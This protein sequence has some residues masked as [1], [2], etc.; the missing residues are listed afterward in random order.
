MIFKSLYPI[1][2]VPSDVVYKAAG[3]L[4][5][6]AH[7][8]AASVQVALLR[9]LI[10]IHCA[11]ED[12]NALSSLYTVFFN[13]LG[14]MDIRL[15]LCHLLATITRKKHVRPYR[16]EIL[17]QLAH[18]VP[19]EPALEKLTRIYDHLGSHSPDTVGGK[20]LAVTFA[21]PDPVWG[22]R[23]RM[24]QHQAGS[25]I[26]APG[27]Y[28]EPFTYSS[29]RNGFQNGSSLSSTRSKEKSRD[30]FEMTNVD[31]IAHNLEKL[32]IPTIVVQDLNDRLLHQYLF[33]QSK[34]VVERQL[35]DVL[36]TLFNGMLEGMA[37][38]ETLKRSALESVLS[39]VRFTMVR[40][41]PQ[42]LCH[43]LI[44]VVTTKICNQLLAD[45]SQRLGRP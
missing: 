25:S 11:L 26:V 27:T 29:L 23:L 13:M 28:T 24:I 22:E 42:H 19:R 20:A 17:Q 45:L 43:L 44:Y 7:K 16:L 32:A 15:P 21:H 8:P 36:N 41:L 9:W 6:G 10:M 18:D 40:F 37:K 34:E 31:G 33:T 5:H 35:N 14:R 30:A 2:K 39:H 38:G 4:G 12:R 3:S 1:R